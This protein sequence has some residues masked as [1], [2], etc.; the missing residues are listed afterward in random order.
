[1]TRGNEIQISAVNH[2]LE[3]EA[4]AIAMRGNNAMKYLDGTTRETPDSTQL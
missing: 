3:E 4:R 1:M 2:R